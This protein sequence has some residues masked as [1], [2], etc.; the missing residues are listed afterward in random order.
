MAN[1]ECDVTRVSPDDI[2]L[3]F[4]GDHEDAAFRIL[5]MKVA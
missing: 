1:I 4:C 3:T 2:E 5:V